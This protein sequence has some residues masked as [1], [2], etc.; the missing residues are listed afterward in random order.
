ML[1]YAW[2]EKIRL[3]KLILGAK[4]VRIEAISL[5]LWFGYYCLASF[6]TGTPLQ[7]E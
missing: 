2:Q 3:L 1:I 5:L 4:R 6:Y 7:Y